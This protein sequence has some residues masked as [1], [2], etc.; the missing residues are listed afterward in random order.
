MLER[1]LRARANDVVCAERSTARRWNSSHS[2]IPTFIPGMADIPPLVQVGKP[3][4][5]MY[6]ARAVFPPNHSPAN[7][8]SVLSV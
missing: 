8:C 4:T 7:P 2:Y 3:I 1:K 5:L 6:E